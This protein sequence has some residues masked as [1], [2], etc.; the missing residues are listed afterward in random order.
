MALTH[1]SYPCFDEFFKHFKCFR[2]LHVNRKRIPNF[3]S[4][5]SKTFV[6]N[7]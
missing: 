3:W 5:R 6:P 4:K 7:S 1:F 2:E